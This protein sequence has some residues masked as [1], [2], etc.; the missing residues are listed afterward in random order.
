MKPVICFPGLCLLF[1][2]IGTPHAG[3]GQPLPANR[4]DSAKKSQISETPKVEPA[5]IKYGLKTISTMEEYNKLIAADSS[6]QLIALMNLIPGLKL[7]IR[8][9]TSNNIMKKPLYT[10]A[11]AY[12]RSPAAQSLKEVQ[13]ELRPMGYGL[14]IFDG[15]RPYAVT[16]QFYEKFLD[17]VFVASPYS[18]SRHNRGCAVDLTLINL[19]TGKELKMPTP[20]DSFTREAAPDFPVRDPVALKNRELLKAVMTRHNFQLYPSEWWHFDF[21]GWNKYPVMNLSFDMLGGQ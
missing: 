10:I 12:M 15:Y 17:S 19:K 21:V 4:T 3:I 13:E 16:V 14:K 8:Y 9:A 1:F 5:F 7:D 6:Q 2:L 11:T 18:G 20:Y